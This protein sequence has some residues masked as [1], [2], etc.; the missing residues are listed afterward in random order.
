MRILITG[1]SG[2]LGSA[3][4]INLHRQ[5]HHIALLLRP[6]SVLDRLG[7]LT[8]TFQIGFF[9]SDQEIDDFVHLVQP[10]VVIHTACA[11]GRN[12]ESMVQLTDVNLRF[13]LALLESSLRTGEKFVFINTATILDRFLSPY[14]LS[15]SQFPDWGKYLAKQPK[16]DFRFINVLLQHMYG[17]GDDPS[18]FSAHVL[19]TCSRNKPYLKLTEGEQRRD[20]IYIEDVVAA[21]SALVENI[22]KLDR[23]MDLEVGTGYAPTIREFV[24]IVHKLTSSKTK[25]LFGAIPYRA[26]EAM[27]CQ[28]DIR[29]MQSLGWNP[30]FDLETGLKE[31][32]IRELKQ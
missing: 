10:D 1:A 17:P 15:K 31:T 11:Y 18:K 22:D 30:R 14:A 26:N 2:F 23:Y 8:S 27:N 5:G 32:I 12:G 13:G 29:K 6:K 19:H 7:N 3:L 16:L 20:F 24:E 4:A 9:S 25:L 21:Y 28:A